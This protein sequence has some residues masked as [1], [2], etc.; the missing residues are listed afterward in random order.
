MGS[1]TADNGDIA[2]QQIPEKFPANC[3]TQDIPHDGFTLLKP[4]RPTGTSGAAVRTYGIRCANVRQS[5]LVAW[6]TRDRRYRIVPNS[7]TPMP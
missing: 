5:S 7:Q 3:R 2:S 1:S 4:S 6:F